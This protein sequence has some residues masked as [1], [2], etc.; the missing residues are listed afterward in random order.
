MKL[1]LLGGGGFRVPL[2]FRTLL[3]DRS[4]HRVTHLTL[5]DTDAERL[6]VIHAILAAM[7]EDH[8]NPPRLTI[9]TGLEHAVADAEFVFSAIR[10]GGTKGRAVEENIARCCGVLGQETTG[11][12]GLNYALRGIPTALAIART[13]QHVAPQAYLINFT[14][15]AGIITEVSSRILGDRVIGICDSPVG[16]ARR[17]LSTLESA[18]LVPPGTASK[19]IADDDQVRL[20]YVG[21]NHLGWLQRLLVGGVDV[22]PRLLER[23]DLIGTFEEGRLFGAEWLQMLGAVPNEYLHY[24]YFAR[25]AREADAAVEAT[26]G[27]FLASQQQDFYAQAAA[28]S[29][30][31]AYRL[32]DATRLQREQTYMASSRLAAGGV[33]RD[34]EDLESGGYDR[35]ALAV[36]KALAFDETADLIVNVRNAGHLPELPDDAVIEAP[37]RIGAAG[38]T[39]LPVT[40]LPDHAVGLVQSVKYAERTAIR[41]ALEGSRDLAVAAFAHHPLIDGVGVAR[42]LLERAQRE[43]PELAYLV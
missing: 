13:I 17:V 2:L 25:E 30:T 20:D 9:A 26:R 29:G 7:A 37:C 8:P 19:V 22:L 12:G 10:V 42:A 32:W 21:L 41:A 39:P 33:E 11:F 18:D 34:E 1:A 3:A 23:P 40:E 35:V 15:P 38:A 27:V 43:F 6:R 28:R 14:N 16:L 5:W 24:Y 4:E 36:L 31:E